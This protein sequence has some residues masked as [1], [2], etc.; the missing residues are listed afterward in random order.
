M[1]AVGSLARRDTIRN[2]WQALYASPAFE[3]RFVLVNYNDSWLYSIKQ[4]NR[5]YSNLVRLEN[6]ELGIKE[7]YTI[8]TI[9]Y[10]KYIVI[11][12]GLGGRYYDFISKIDDDVFLVATKFFTDY[13]APRLYPI[14]V[15]RTL[16]AR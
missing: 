2:T 5:T 13:L 16:I 3:T 7:A 14:L 9:E 8:K 12:A 1:S 4:E 6:V 11:E 10:F 15:T